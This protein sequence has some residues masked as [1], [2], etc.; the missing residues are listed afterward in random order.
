MRIFNFM[1][2]ALSDML[3]ILNFSLFVCLH[4]NHF[5]KKLKK[6]GIK[7]PIR[8]LHFYLSKTIK[9]ARKYIG[10]SV[11]VPILFTAFVRQKDLPYFKRQL[12]TN[13]ERYRKNTF[14]CEQQIRCHF[15]LLGFKNYVR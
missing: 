13:K 3:S 2:H 7:V 4:D 1:F 15:T 8:L 11:R 14:I 10:K 9:F 12:Q 6:Y 5:R